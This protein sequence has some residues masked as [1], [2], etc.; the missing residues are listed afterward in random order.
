MNKIKLFLFFCVMS[1]SMVLLSAQEPL[2]QSIWV[3]FDDI[4]CG[5]SYETVHEFIN[6]YEQYQL[7]LMFW[8]E[9]TL[10]YYCHRA[11]LA[12]NTSLINVEDLR[13]LL[14]N[15]SRIDTIVENQSYSRTRQ[16]AISLSDNF[17]ENSFL[18]CYE[19][20]GIKGS[21]TASDLLHID[22]KF[23]YYHFNDS[24]IY[25][26]DLIQILQ[27]DDDVV[28]AETIIG[29]ID[30][31]I[32]G[33]FYDSIGP[34]EQDIFF[35]E[36]SYIDFRILAFGIFV[37]NFDVNE[38]SEFDV[39]ELLR[40]DERVRN[41][42]LRSILTFG[43]Q[44]CLPVKKDTDTNELDESILPNIFISVY[45]NPVINTDVS[46]FINHKDIDLSK[47]EQRVELSIYNIKG[48]LI[49]RSSN[50]QMMDNQNIFIWNRKD[51]NN[52]D[53]ASGI[54]FYRIHTDN[55]TTSGKFLIIK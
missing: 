45:Q 11:L 46:F 31:E 33:S 54:Y 3:T 32:S 28:F 22:T 23:R 43:S 15:D 44:I 39:V 27:N 47:N 12:F 26:H 41:A 30:G 8:Q 18:E 9:L 6:D 7:Y 4:H 40:E 38:Y 2:G 36:F 21:I 51:M 1:L 55:Q 5:S 52:N 35:N 50:F 34:E 29:W 48:Q 20:Y 16:L 53:V 19:E 24:L 37:G 13:D 42:N 14:L 25:G 49:N 17:S 10:S